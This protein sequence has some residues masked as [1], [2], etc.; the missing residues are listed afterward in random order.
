M[1]LISESGVMRE[2]VI[3]IVYPKGE[4]IFEKAVFHARDLE[5]AQRKAA[6]ICFAVNRHFNLYERTQD[7]FVEA[8]E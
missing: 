3:G 7:G 6:S 2:Y 1:A 5:A 4:V 8:T